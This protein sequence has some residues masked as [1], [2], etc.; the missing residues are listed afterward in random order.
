[1]RPLL[2]P[3]HYTSQA[4]FD[5]EL[6]TIF[7]RLWLLAGVTPMLQK[8]LDYR[9]LTLAGKPVVL[10]NHGGVIRAF[11]NICR[12][13]M[14]RIQSEE[15][16]N[17]G[18]VCPYHHWCYN[19]DGQLTHTHKDPKVFNFAEGETEDIRLTQYPVKV[20]GS[21]IFV[22]LSDAPLPIE[23]QFDA[24]TTSLLETYTGQMDSAFIYTRYEGDFNWKT[25]MENIKDSLHVPCLHKSTFPKHFRVDIA[26]DPSIHGKDAVYDSQNAG[27]QQATTM[28]MI[29]M[30][31]A[32][33]LD[34]QTLVAQLDSKG[35]Y[36]TF[37]LF[38][39]VNLM[40]VD[41]TSFAIQ[42][43]NPLAADKTEMHMMVALTRPV[44][45]FPHKPVVLWE[46]LLSDMT[47][48]QE[49]I[50]CL[51]AL[52]R[53]LASSDSDFIHG[54]YET[55]ILDF[56]AAYLAQTGSSEPDATR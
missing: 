35:R 42:T 56:H 10:Q 18:L 49:D 51:E 4:W 55:G 3:H 19:Q 38:P 48:L 2:S 12:H 50:E 11:S 15:F 41:G 5:T 30:Q 21:L 13:R 36:Q 34:W 8:H 27:L 39:N 40:V 32:P 54:A 44:A 9:T 24:H 26:S 31:S 20:I 33:E 37:H 53:N 1:M 45:D 28:G 43:Y 25:G 29:A 17:R 52:Q 22:N 23:E 6:K 14:A 46:H 7:N 47:V 16:G